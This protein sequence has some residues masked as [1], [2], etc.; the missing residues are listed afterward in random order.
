[1]SKAIAQVAANKG[2]SDIVEMYAETAPLGTRAALEQLADLPA[3]RRT[4]L[5]DSAVFTIRAPKEFGAVDSSTL[6]SIA[7]ASEL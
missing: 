4:R 5:A 7:R 6:E 1:M 3:G 2:W